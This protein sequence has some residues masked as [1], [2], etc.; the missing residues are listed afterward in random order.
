M[1]AP[2]VLAEAVTVSRTV[3]GAS[4]FDPGSARARPTTTGWEIGVTLTATGGDVLVTPL[5]SASARR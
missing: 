5:L 3:A 4:R 1:D 2:G